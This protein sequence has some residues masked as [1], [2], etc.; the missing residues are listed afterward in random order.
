[1][2]YFKVLKYNKER[3][4][5]IDCSFVSIDDNDNVCTRNLTLVFKTNLYHK[6]FGMPK[7]M[8]SEGEITEEQLSLLLDYLVS[9]GTVITNGK[10]KFSLP[11]TTIFRIKQL[12]I[13][14]RKRHNSYTKRKFN[15]FDYVTVYKGF[16]D[17]RLTT[18]I[19]NEIMHKINSE[20]TTPNFYGHYD[21]I[22]YSD[23]VEATVVGENFS[24]IDTFYYDFGGWI[25][26]NR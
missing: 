10:G 21:K 9:V 26:D 14:S 23:I 5:E 24:T 17:G 15:R 12:P 6:V 4:W 22:D 20:E 16:F 19:L 2:K 13:T 18:E 7:C 1:M 8:C 3:W 25:K 11:D